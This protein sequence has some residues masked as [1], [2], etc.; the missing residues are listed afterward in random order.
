MRRGF[1]VACAAALLLAAPAPATSVKVEI[2]KDGFSPAHVTVAA[3]DSL[4]WV[5]K[6]SSDHRLSCA[7]CRFRSNTLK[8]G[9]SYGFTFL[10]PGTFIVVDQLN[11]NKKS[12][13]TVKKPP[14]SVA[15]AASTSMLPYGG[16]VTVTGT[17]SSR[18]AGA[19]VEILAQRCIEPEIKVV[20]TVKSEKGGAY[21][22][23]GRPSQVTSYHARYSA[24]SGTVVSPTLRIGVAP[25]VT[26]K[27]VAPGKFS[28]RVTAGKRLVG[29]AV[30]F[31]RFAPKQHRWVTSKVAVLDHGSGSAVPLRNSS[32]SSALVRSQLRKGTKVRALLRSFQAL[33]CY[34][35]A[36]SKT[37]TA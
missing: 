37:T 35:T 12:I 11:G 14:A 15:A 27:R 4:S 19:K 32:V 31:Q 36:W 30:M 2:T 33:P 17:V 24:P 25:L 18:K 28:I 1:L 21:T 5:N 29:K 16:A 13:V 22:Y 26:L 6:D 34:S 10:R 9:G 20:A 3:G 8:E 7:T 23:R